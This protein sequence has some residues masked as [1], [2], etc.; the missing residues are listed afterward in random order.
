[1]RAK[2]N[3]LDFVDQVAQVEDTSTRSVEFLLILSSAS[4]AVPV[5]WNS[6]G[7]DYG[8]VPSNQ[9]RNR[10][11][12]PFASADREIGLAAS[13]IQVGDRLCYFPRCSTVAVMRWTG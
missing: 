13:N 6:H 9:E 12:R 7:A 5:D 3:A 4:Y 10:A 2:I 8:P 11:M 1:M